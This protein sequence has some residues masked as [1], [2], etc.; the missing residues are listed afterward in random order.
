MNYTSCIKAAFTLAPQPTYKGFEVG[1]RILKHSVII[2][3][4]I[5]GGLDYSPLPACRYINSVAEVLVFSIGNLDISHLL[6][7]SYQAQTW[8]T[9]KEETTPREAETKEKTI[10]LV[11]RS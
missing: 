4:N 11:Q 10:M 5:G 6:I 3:S 9:C 7:G 8:A 2:Q 1:N